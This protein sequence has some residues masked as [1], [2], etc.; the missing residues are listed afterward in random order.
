MR[1]RSKFSR[2][3]SFVMSLSLVAGDTLPAFAADSDSPEEEVS[4]VSI[5]EVQDDEEAGEDAPAE[6]APVIVTVDDVDADDEEFTFVPGYLANPFEAESP[7]L[8]PELSYRESRAR[9]SGDPSIEYETVH[10]TSEASSASA[11]DSAYPYGYDG[12][13]LNYF[14]TNFPATRDQN[15]YGSCW[16]HSAMGIAEFNLIS[17]GKANKNIDLSELH[18]NYWSY[19][20]GTASPVAGD[21]GDRVSFSPTEESSNI[22]D[23]GGDVGMAT[24]QLM[25]QRGFALESV[26][27]Y[28]QKDYIAGGGTL[29][30]S[31]ER[32]DSYYLEN[33]YKIDISKAENRSKVKEAIIDNGAVGVS[34]YATTAMSASYSVFYSQ[35]YNAYYCNQNVQSN[36]AVCAVGWDDNFPKEYFPT[37]PSNDGA[38]L[39]RNSWS[40]TSAKDY[41]SYFWMSYEDA[42]LG[43]GWVYEVSDTFPYDNHYY[44]D[45]AIHGSAYFQGYKQF[46]NI[47][48]I[49]GECEKL[50]AVDF[51]ISYL[52][53]SN[54]AYTVEIYK[55]P[56]ATNP[57]SG[58]KVGG[59]SGVLDYLGQYTIK[60]DEPVI[61]EQ[62]DKFSV[63]VKFDKNASI[64][65]ETGLVNYNGVNST[66]GAATGQSF[67]ASGSYWYDLYT[68]YGSQG[69]GNFIIAALTTDVELGEDQSKVEL[70][71]ETLSFT[72]KGA[73]KQ[74][75]V[76]VYDRFGNLNSNATVTYTSSD[77]DVA[78]V[79]DTGLITS[80]G[81]GTATITA[82][83]GKLTATCAVTV[84]VAKSAKPSVDKA[85]GTV[86][87]PGDMLSVTCATEGAEV[88]YTTNGTEPTKS[89]SMVTDGKI[90]VKGSA[91][92]FTLKLRA[93]SDEY[94]PSDIATYTYTL[95][96]KAGASLDKTELEL[97]STA[98]T[99]T[100]TATLF[101]EAGE[102]VSNARFTWESSDANVAT[103]AAGK[104]TAVGSGSAVITATSGDYS[105]VCNV[106]V[107]F[108]KAGKPA[109]DKSAKTL[110]I[111]DTIK[112][113]SVTE[114]AD[115]YY[116]LDGSDP[117]K[118]STKFSGSI[119]VT[120]DMV[121]QEITLKAIA[122]ANYY[123]P[124][125]IFTYTFTVES[126]A[127]I[128]LSVTTLK[129]TSA[130]PV[131]KLTA[132][133]YSFDGSIDN[134]AV[135]SWNSADESV[136]TVADGKITAAGSGTTTITA[137]SGK[138]S[139]SCEVNVTM[140]KLAT[141]SVHEAEGTIFS[142]GDEIIVEYGNTAASVYYTLDGSD[143]TK[144]STLTNG[145]IKIEKELAGKAFTLKLRAFAD[146]YEASDILS[147]D[148]SVEDLSELK[149]SKSLISFTKA[150]AT[151]KLTAVVCD[152]TGTVSSNAVISWSSS[153]EAVATV[154][155][156]VV[157]AV[158]SGKVVITASSGSLS[159]KCD[160]VVVTDEER[161]P[162]VSTN[163][164]LDPET[165]EIN[166]IGNTAQINVTVTD[167]YGLI[168]S[169]P[170]VSFES[171][172][173]S[174]ATVSKT[175]AVK[176]VSAGDAVITVKSGEV[177]ANCTV[178]V[179]LSKLA[180]P[181]ALVNSEISYRA[182]MEIT[183]KCASTGADIRYTT[184]GSDPAEDSEL[185]TGKFEITKEMAG[186][187]ITLKLRAFADGCEAS[188]I[189]SY[190]ITVEDLS[191]I[192]L[193]NTKI[194]FTETGV[195]KKLRATVY[196]AAGEEDKTAVISW[197]SSD[198]AVVTVED[199]KVTAV[200]EGTAVITAS[201]GK[202]TAD[203]QVLVKIFSYEEPQFADN[204]IV[205]PQEVRFNAKGQ[206]KQLSV[207]VEDQYGLVIDD[208]ELYFAS[209]DDDIA[210]VDDYGTITA[211]SSGYAVI[212]VCCDEVYEFC[213]VY[214][215]I[216]GDDP[217]EPTEPEEKECYSVKFYV[218]GILYAQEE[219]EKGSSAADVPADLGDDFI[220]WTDKASG[221]HWNPTSPVYS[222]L[223]LEARFADTEAVSAYSPIPGMEDVDIYMVKGQKFQ[224]EGKWESSKPS[225]VNISKKGV[226][227]AKKADPYG[228]VIFNCE[229][230][231]DYRVV[232]VVQPTMPKTLTI[233]AGAT[234][235]LN[236]DLDIL[237]DEYNVAWT[238]SAPSIAV[239]NGGSIYGIA[240]G[241]A[242]ITSV[243]NGKTYT[244]KVKVNDTEKVK[245]D[246][247]T[248]EITLS[249]MQ[250][251][252]TKLKG[253]WTADG[254]SMEN[255]STTNKPVYANSVVSITDA[256]KITAIGSG[257][258][259]LSVGGR[260]IKVTV[261]EPVEQVQ[262]IAKGKKKTLKFTSVKNIQGK[263]SSS[264][265]SVVNVNEKGAV[266]P[267]KTGEAVITCTYN[268]TGVEGAGFT[269]VTR[270]YVEDPDLGATTGLSKV[271][272]TSYTYN[273]TVGTTLP[274]RFTQNSS[275]AVYQSVAFKSSKP[276]VAYVDECGVLHA[277][278]SGK[279]KLTAKING[280]SVT[281]TV[282][283]N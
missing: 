8:D 249:P 245:V 98:P 57:V 256:G 121:D 142:I 79:S 90:K 223:E 184:D 272:N 160:V 243:V 72:K 6:E 76:K 204:I 254:K 69:A 122:Y 221:D 33:A 9:L 50:E 81:S 180:K 279:T 236:M 10:A 67:F 228:T 84:T 28:T 93:F 119:K 152:A 97:T 53:S 135:V 270:F 215:D 87:Y 2:I 282:N 224:L 145:T 260:K 213:D 242:T 12:A 36:H 56:S 29:A 130:N 123:D 167:Q 103:V 32:Q 227:T 140:S 268:P 250:S 191:V 46:G 209:S 171:S 38:W 208:P 127:G 232:Y 203:C 147:I 194:S 251:V 78:T 77:E 80:T 151:E 153:D 45:S 247:Y 73:T 105:A 274:L 71:P 16:A 150:G 138:L 220:G 179:T 101:D 265:S 40:T 44:Y 230:S 182:G 263:W 212:C 235:K 206:T 261:K 59:A 25:R 54:T 192:E 226:L 96:S 13:W 188:E 186:K 86:L 23:N 229:D 169:K 132:T 83:S 280:K 239:V 26:A 139:A 1:K 108:S 222:D 39:I 176:S 156:G 109:A 136:A 172:D 62:G 273:T 18:L 231:S 107:S 110:R 51:E 141:P 181:V 157:K 199:G 277:I 214:V 117:D 118:S 266:T 205:T 30:A 82:K 102:E 158:A 70:T 178:N 37:Q 283:V 183:V 257:V 68:Q 259:N 61:L 278:G 241:S 173:E 64:A 137:T 60:L 248:D 91:G 195:S 15:P 177:S 267:L 22:L 244:C 144:E 225:I 148:Y 166:G 4:I 149:L 134:S 198:E 21:T 17:H 11:S 19:N 99:A 106:T 95:D 104:V 125:D 190:E 49:S 92:E 94:D 163:I 146:Y 14:T 55:N 189:A 197:S 85:S 193:S 174:I 196:D 52:S 126:K 7:A 58:T 269:Y 233:Q 100:I 42:S 258:T 155:K 218:G 113:S 253:E 281:I 164:I 34:Y 129:L 275:Y 48:T 111:S 63:V 238:S 216:S 74:L 116:T 276:A 262:Y 24:Q 65:L 89:S 66:A 159:A 185:L 217:F 120:S 175:G 5:D 114:D 43:G 211:V 20:Q 207:T 200:G 234:D 41:A 154:D 161:D 143:P 252:A 168:I 31:T 187:T 88:Y 3:L 170:S 27:P 128:S 255:I 201:S 210:T 202:L 271:K 240:K 75:N 264:D 133:V 124:S 35:T 115:I 47:Y 246:A 219:V 237:A 165:L 131:T 162:A 112:L